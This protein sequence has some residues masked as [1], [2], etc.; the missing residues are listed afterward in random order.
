M[1]GKYLSNMGTQIKT[2]F[3]LQLNSNGVS[4]ND[5]EEILVE[6]QNSING[7]NLK[8]LSEWERNHKTDT[9]YYDTKIQELRNQK[10]ELLFFLNG[11]E[12]KVIAQNP[13]IH[14]DKKFEA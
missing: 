8:R 13:T 2:N 3:I 12:P 5:I 14:S 11:E 7:Y 1:S 6:I 9:T 10:T 4:A